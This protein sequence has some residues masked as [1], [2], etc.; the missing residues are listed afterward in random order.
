MRVP[1]FAA[2][3][4]AALAAP[5]VFESLHAEPLR[6]QR[7][8]SMTAQDITGGRH[9][10]RSLDGRGAFIVALTDPEA[11]AAAKAWNDAAD[12]RVP[13]SVRR[14]TN[15]SIHVPS[16][17]MGMARSRA[18]ASASRG[19]W[20]RIWLDGNRGMARTLGLSTS[21]VPYV[22]DL[23]AQGNVTAVVH[24]T[25]NSPAADAIWRGLA[26]ARVATTATRGGEALVHVHKVAKPRAGSNHAVRHHRSGSA[27]QARAHR[28]GH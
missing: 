23:D 9:N 21:R 19:E 27:H 4:A 16:F 11:G 22:F 20:P 13:P 26:T 18:R 8:P 14:G 15:V 17:A 5:S 1:V 10:S 24:A 7:F 28:T 3:L 12:G 25:A 2:T 6:G